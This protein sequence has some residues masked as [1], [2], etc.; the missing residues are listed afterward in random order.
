MSRTSTEKS[1][2][3]EVTSIDGVL[4]SVVILF[5]ISEGS[6]RWYSVMVSDVTTYVVG[7][8]LEVSNIRS[9]SII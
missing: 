8:I 9:T 5:L 1:V 4:V 2:D 3:D 7:N 6:R